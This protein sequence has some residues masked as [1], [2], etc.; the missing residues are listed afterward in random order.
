[1]KKFHIISA[2]LIILFFA[3]NAI[4]GQSATKDECVVKCHEAAAL[5]NSKGLE[6]A[7]KVIGDPEG[8]FVWK[9]SY[10]FMMNLDGKMLAHP[11]KPELTKQEHLFLMTDPTDKALFVHFVNLA[12]KV[13]HGWVE[14]MW[15][16]PG[17]NTPWKKLTYIYRVPNQD[18]FVG[19]GVYVGGM[20]Y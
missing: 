3:T 10:V 19:A 17:K 14:Y 4:A 15:P 16:K 2:V 9:D 6:K 18:I 8:P 5:I 11:I 12:R 20:M 13:G 1:M 7:V